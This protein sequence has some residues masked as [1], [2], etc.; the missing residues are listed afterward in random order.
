LFASTNPSL[1]ISILG[2][3]L[4][5]IVSI[6]LVIYLFLKFCGWAKSFKLSGGFKK[7]VYILTG[8]GAVILNILYALGNKAVTHEG[9]WGLATITLVISL[10]W[11]WIFAFTLM[12]ETKTE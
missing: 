1:E 11:V 8:L 9:D 3:P 12:A 4:V 7:M 5:A 10:I 2:N 6:L